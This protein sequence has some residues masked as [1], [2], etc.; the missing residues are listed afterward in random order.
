MKTQL[1]NFGGIFL[2]GITLTACISE[3]NE[4]F[5]ELSQEKGIEVRGKTL[6]F[7]DFESYEN[8]IQDPKEILSLDFQSI[9]KLTK[10]ES[11]S[12][13]ARIFSDEESK[14]LE[15]YQGSLILDIL[16]EDRMVIIEDKLF[17]LDFINRLVAVTSNSS[18]RES[19]KN[20][21]YDSNEVFLFSFEDNVL[22]LLEIGSHGTVNSLKELKQRSK[23]ENLFTVTVGCDWDECRFVQDV[24]GDQG[25]DYRIE[26]K[27]VYQSSGIY[28]KLFSQVKHMK[29]SSPPLYSGE[30]TYIEISYDF[31]LKSKR[32][33]YGNNGVDSGINTR[34]KFD[35][36]FE[37]QYYS[38]SRGL[39]QYRL[40]THFIVDVGG[41]HGNGLYGNSFW[42][43]NLERISKG[44]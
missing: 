1:K 29:K 27:H 11:A 20:G 43:F 39:D 4:E 33:S 30:S 31:W 34:S 12:S 2:L 3:Q 41:D 35:D 5:L 21:E 38:L 6:S 9:A 44:L 36:D 28:F 22:D 18:L 25:M 13:N 8:A 23:N 24:P 7:A 40:D 15:E 19:L 14:A 26:A 16:D 42:D 10:T 17:H 32:D 37:I